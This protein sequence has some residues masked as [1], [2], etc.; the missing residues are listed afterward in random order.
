[1]PPGLVDLLIPSVHRHRQTVA[2]ECAGVI[3]V[4]VDIGRTFTDLIGFPRPRGSVHPGE[5]PDHAGQSGA[6]NHRLIDKSD[7]DAAAIDELIHGSTIAINTLIA[8]KGATTGLVV[9][10]GTRD[11]YIIGRRQP[12][13]VLLAE[14]Y[15]STAGI[16]YFATLFT[17]NFDP[18]KLLGLISLLAAMAIVLNEIVPRAEVH[19]GRWRTG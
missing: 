14:L 13:G 17:Q 6:G 4:A 9:T 8:R 12:P 19:F 1:V 16:G 7:V 5:E 15:V 18:T 3:F 2:E 11:V 10:R